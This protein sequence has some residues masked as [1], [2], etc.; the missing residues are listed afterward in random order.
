MVNSMLREG[1][2]AEQASLFMASASFVVQVV[3]A[4]AEVLAEHHIT[5]GWA[6]RE[7]ADRLADENPDCMI[8]MRRI[9]RD[10]PVQCAAYAPGREALG[11]H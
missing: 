9:R 1:D 10:N 7:M 2:I 4:H 5:G 3:G 6:M 11:G 8:A